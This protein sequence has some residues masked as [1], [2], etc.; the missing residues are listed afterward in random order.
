MMSW[1]RSWSERL[2]RLRY[3]VRGKL[4]AVVVATTI[5]AVLVA[6]VAMLS[7]DLTVYRRSWVSDLSTQANILALSTTPAL[8]FDDRDTATRNL[9]ALQARPE[10]QVAAI[11]NRSGALYARYVRD[12][13]NP[14]PRQLSH[15]TFG[16]R[17]AGER[18]Q[19][20]QPIMQKGE[21]LG[22]ISL[23]A[24]YDVQGRINAYFGIFGFVI[25]LSV[26]VSLV[27][28]AVLQRVITDPLDAMAD[29]ARQVVE[30][31]DYTPRAE[32]S[33][34]IEIGLVVAAFNRMLDEVQHRTIALKQTQEALRE[35]DRRKDEFLATLAHELRNPLAPIRHAVK[36][37]ELPAADE[38]QRQWGRDVIARQVQ[39]MALLLDDLLEVSRITRGRLELKKT[40][41]DLPSLIAAAVETARPLMESKQHRLETRLPAEPVRLQVDPLRISQALSNL[42]TNAAKYTDVG[43]RIALTAALDDEHQLAISVADSGIGLSPQAIPRLFEMFS[44][45]ASPV[46]RAEGGL[47]IGL[48]LVKGLVE[49]H[50]GTVEAYNA[51]LGCGSRFTIRLP[52]SVVLKTNIAATASGEAQ[53]VPHAG[54]R[55]RILLADDNRDAVDMLALVLKMAGYEVY[56]THS[57]HEALDVGARVRPEVFILDIGMPEISGYEL[58]SRIRRQTW[59]RDALL[60]ALTGWGQREDK[61]R[62]REAGFDHHL[63]K[64]VDP[65]QLE[66]LLRDIAP[67]PTDRL[68][69]T[70]RGRTGPSRPGPSPL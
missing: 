57:G 7:H 21:W 50:G 53:P 14:P 68:R 70:D 20:I 64:P 63:T 28:S 45:V 10:V 39:R 17:I 66:R 13:A 69:G 56:A 37:L 52:A 48:A 60:I 25:V 30:R 11:Y 65:D 40:Q 51:G 12:G 3:S 32:P 44:Q 29:V 23:N 18:I 26:L 54:H 55:S 35:A 9:N 8:L 41:V 19:L 6:G 31:E 22:T 4:V 67:F 27:L 59:G 42:L 47:G 38:R 46:D 58:A 15:P 1:M 49:M 34:D 62:S 33:K 24:R 2:R 5:I 16:P 61:E 36:L 43:G